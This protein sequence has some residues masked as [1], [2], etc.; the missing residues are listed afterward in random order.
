MQAS[1][2]QQ[3]HQLHYLQLHHLLQN[4]PFRRFIRS[5]AIFHPRSSASP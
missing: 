2:E 3:L 5:T 4:F 1:A